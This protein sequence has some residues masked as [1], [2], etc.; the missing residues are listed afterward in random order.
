VLWGCVAG[1]RRVL[2]ARVGTDSRVGLRSDQERA[3]AMA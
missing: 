3:A 1:P 2:A